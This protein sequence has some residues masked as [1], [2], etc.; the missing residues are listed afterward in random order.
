MKIVTCTE[1]G[2]CEN[3]F[4]WNVKFSHE[5]ELC[6]TEISFISHTNEFA[7]L[8]FR[9]KFKLLISII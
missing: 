3:L 5:S 1:K 9:M 4:L 6:L 2:I 7:E 8:N